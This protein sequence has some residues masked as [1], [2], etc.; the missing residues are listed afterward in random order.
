MLRLADVYLPLTGQGGFVPKKENGIWNLMGSRMY[1]PVFRPLFFLE[2]QKLRRI[3]KQML[4]AAKHGLV[5]HLW[6]H[7]HNIG[8]RTEEHLAQ[9]EEILSCFDTLKEQYGMQSMNMGELA[10]AMEAGIG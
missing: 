5:F 2:K 6:W 4:H 9:L 8:V 7:P 1:K 10:E 3:K